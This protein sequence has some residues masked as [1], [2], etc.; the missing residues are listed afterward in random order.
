MKSGVILALLLCGFI[1]RFH[2]WQFVIQERKGLG[3]AV[4]LGGTLVTLSIAAVLLLS[5]GG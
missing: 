1:I 3:F 5:T 2:G 4:V